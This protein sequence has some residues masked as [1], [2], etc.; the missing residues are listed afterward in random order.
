MDIMT[1]ASQDHSDIVESLTF[2]QELQSCF[3]GSDI[4]KFNKVFKNH[5]PE[6]FKFEEDFLFPIVLKNGTDKEKALMENLKKEHAQILLLINDLD[7]ILHQS[8]KS[9]PEEHSEKFNELKA[10]MI[11]MIFEH[12]HKEDTE[13]YPIIKKLNL[14][15]NPT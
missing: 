11:S 12:A 4:A 1:K 10:K 2:Y 15:K 14:F 6:H 8:C 7:N 5:I 9:L 3:F 13:F